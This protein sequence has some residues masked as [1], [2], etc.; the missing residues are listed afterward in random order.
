M[1]STIPVCLTLAC[2]GL[3]APDASADDDDDLGGEA[4]AS[5]SVS[6]S[7]GSA[8]ASSSG[9]LGNL[10]SKKLRVHVESDVLSATIGAGGGGPAQAIIGFG[11]GRLTA[12][13]GS[14][15]FAT[16]VLSIGFGAVILNGHGAVGG[17][18]AFS[19][20]ATTGGGGVL[21]GGRL[22]GYFNYMFNSRGRITP[23]VGGRLGVGGAN[24]SFGGLGGGTFFPLI[25]AQGGIHLFLI[26]PV[27]LDI[28]LAL[29][30]APIIAT[31]GGGLAL[32]GINISVPR[33]GLST[34][35]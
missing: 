33:L 7:G 21:V 35:F 10:S 27:S 5:A 22:I 4:S 12:P 29:D 3:Y 8:S 14:I 23:F 28:A 24:A 16:P 30:Y 11:V 26:E 20:D 6:S 17:Q 2:L 25:G 9:G 18:A 19:M 31:G 34:W 15:F 1:L 13:D 32:H